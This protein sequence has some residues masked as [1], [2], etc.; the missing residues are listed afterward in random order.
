MLGED[1]DNPIFRNALEWRIEFPQVLDEKGNFI[2]FDAII[3]NPP[4]IQLQKNGGVLG[5]LYEGRDYEVFAKTGDIYALFYE[6]GIRL[7]R[8]LG[9][10][11]FIVSNKWLRAGYG[12]NLREYLL[13][14]NPIT[15]LDLGGEVFESATVDTNILSVQKAK[16]KRK[17]KALTVKNNSKELAKELKENG[18]V[19]TE[20][21][22]ESWFIGSAGEIALKKKIEQIGTPLKDWDVKI[23]YG[24]KTGLNEAFII[25][26]ETK[27]R[28][29]EE[30]PKSAEIIK[31]ILR[32]RDIKRY[33]YDWKDLWII[34]SHNGYGDTPRIEVERDYPAIYKHL[35]QHET[36]ASK[37]SDKG[38]H[39]TNLRN[40]A[41][42]EE[43][44]KDKIVWQ[45]MTSQPSFVIDKD[46][47]FTND[48]ITFLVGKNLSI[49]VGV[50]N[51][52]MTHFIFRRFYA[53]GGLGKEGIRYK[54]TFLQNLPI[55]LITKENESIAKEIST[56]ADKILSIKKQNPT[57]DTDKLENE[58]DS[59][60]YKL[61]KLDQKEIDIIEEKVEK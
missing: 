56:L 23:N 52:K 40:C 53:G 2:G 18:V 16:N 4:Y 38:K 61:Y 37:R 30:D 49:L 51:S 8:D 25:D 3:G 17:L 12:K 6:L 41:Y 10:V 36:K 59:L 5:E 50:L 7:V 44:E 15:L 13:K 27:N 11:S 45:E 29:C 14:Y 48:T 58:I 55:P 33:S 24:I 35:L 9:E 19:L 31:P 39:W 21:S 54:K 34:N 57:T 42:V 46:N 43:F 32:G 22:A 26:T 60:V 28:L 47:C 20:L 1:L